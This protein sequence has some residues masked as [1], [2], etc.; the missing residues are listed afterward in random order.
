MVMCVVL[1]SSCDLLKSDL[2]QE[3]KEANLYK[4][5][6][7][8]P[9]YTPEDL[10]GHLTPYGPVTDDVV[11]FPSTTEDTSYRNIFTMRTT[12]NSSAALVIES[13]TI[14][15][16]LNSYME[17]IETMIANDTLLEYEMSGGNLSGL[18]TSLTRIRDKISSLKTSVNNVG[19]ATAEIGVQVNDEL[20][21]L[22]TYAD[23][24]LT[25]LQGEV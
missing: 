24:V 3:V 12:F 6:E 14:V 19:F 5:F 4:R 13:F 25:D 17:K 22:M 18:S 2:F 15:D 8:I 16:D 10:C 1:L 7:D 21:T 9:Y 20:D 23:E 11:T